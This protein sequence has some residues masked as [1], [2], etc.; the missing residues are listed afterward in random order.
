M[1]QG[2]TYLLSAKVGEEAFVFY[3]GNTHTVVI[4]GS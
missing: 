2:D 4:D 3:A 1:A